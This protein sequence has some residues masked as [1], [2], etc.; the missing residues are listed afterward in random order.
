MVLNEDGKQVL[1]YAERIF[2]QSD[3]MLELIKSGESSAT[4]ILKIGVVSWMPKEHL[5]KFLRPVLFSPHILIQVIQKDLDS[6]LKEA[7]TDRLDIVLCDSPYSGRSKKLIGRKLKQE[8]IY[9]VASKNETLKGSFPKLLNGKK[10]VTYSEASELSDH[11]EV[12]VNDNKFDLKFVAELSDLS[13]MSYIIERG[14]I[15]GFL[16]ET[17]AKEGIKSKRF[18]KKKKKKKAHFDVWAI[19][20]KA[21][22]RDGLISALMKKLD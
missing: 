12:F 5:Y 4:R 19:H 8:K 9:C 14:G 3:E 13:M 10:A 22:K 18:R 6:L 1:D 16:P 15:L 20:K 17:T 2:R 7:Q 21:E 11:I